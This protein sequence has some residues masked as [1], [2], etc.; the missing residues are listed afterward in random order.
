MEADIRDGDRTC[1]LLDDA[2]F[3]A[4]GPRGTPG[5]RTLPQ[6]LA[7]L[8]QGQLLSFDALQMH[9]RQPWYSFLVQIA[10]M[11]L[12]RE[13][14]QQIAA[15]AT[16]WR[17][18]LTA[19]SQGDDAPWHLVVAAPSTP[20][21]MQAPIPE[22]NL[23]AAE[24]V[25]DR[26]TPDALD[27]LITT[28]SHDIKQHRIIDGRPEHWIYG[29]VAL[30]TTGGYLGRGNYGVVRMNGGLGNRPLIGLAPAL[31]WGSR[32]RRD[33]AVLLQ[34]RVEIG[35]AGGFDL[36]DG[37][38]LLWLPPWDGTRRTSARLEQ[39]D[40]FFVEICRRIRFTCDHRG[41]LVCWRKNTACPRVDADGRRGRTGDPWVPIDNRAN[42]ALTL[43]PDGFTY[44]R[45][46]QIWWSEDYTPPVALELHPL[47]ATTD[48]FF[49]ASTM[50][51]GQG[52]TEGLHRR[53]IRVPAHIVHAQTTST[54][55]RARL[56]QRASAWVALANRVRAQVLS[57]S[58]FALFYGG[59]SPSDPDWAAINR[60]VRPFDDAVDALFFDALWAS[61]RDEADRQSPDARWQL[62]LKQLAQE[63]YEAARSSIPQQSIH[64]LR[65]LSSADIQF[66]T[67]LRQN[68][69]A[70]FDQNH[71]PDAP[72][73]A[74]DLPAT[75]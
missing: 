45:I 56:S 17:R 16:A 33:V 71:P 57:A 67:H 29:L 1:S 27:V 38:A 30:Q 65:V 47:D 31:D 15:D 20:A 44:D 42:K 54:E 22:G 7:A 24:Y 75:G 25:A 52:K 40:P 58:I 37:L 26:A 8:S 2:L 14:T 68:L 50:V 10:A 9:Q 59:R 23:E 64:R 11:G 12:A 69:P 19:L 72:R 32:F 5:K 51:R 13:Q 48:F 4:R 63:T 70:A 39:C 74:D 53:I 36:E 61:F 46:Q 35:A 21:F 66:A 6:L 28:K 62:T 49:L 18:R 3:S 60:W 34:N 43:G 41:D 55:E 73:D